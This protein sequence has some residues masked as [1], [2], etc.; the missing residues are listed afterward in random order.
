MVRFLRPS[1]LVRRPRATVVVLAT[2][3]GTIFTSLS[4]VSRQAGSRHRYRHRHMHPRMKVGDIAADMGSNQRVSVIR[5]G[6]NKGHIETTMTA[7]LC[8]G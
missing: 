6:T 1:L 4:M 7:W 5:H 8:D 2:T 3:T